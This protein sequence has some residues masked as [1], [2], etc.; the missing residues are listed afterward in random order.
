[1]D[2]QKEHLY[3]VSSPL[4]LLLDSNYM[5]QAITDEA[6]VGE[7]IGAGL[8]WESHMG[9]LLS[10]LPLLGRLT[11]LRVSLNRE[12][13]LTI[14][15]LN[16]GDE[17]KQITRTARACIKN[18]LLSP[19]EAIIPHIKAVLSQDDLYT[20]EY[21]SNRQVLKSLLKELLTDSDRE[22]IAAAGASLIRTKIVSQLSFSEE[23]LL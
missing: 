18:R 15:A 12:A 20:Q 1:M 11:T 6:E 23:V 16:L 14:E 5:Q 21:I 4:D 13:R 2:N 8:D 7:N 17:T 22:E 10:N 9:T 3:S 19:T